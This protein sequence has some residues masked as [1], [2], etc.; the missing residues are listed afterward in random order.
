MDD[1]VVGVD[2]LFFGGLY[3]VVVGFVVIDLF[4]GIE[5]VG[6]MVDI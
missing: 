3:I 2:D 1:G 5:D 6:L 4:I